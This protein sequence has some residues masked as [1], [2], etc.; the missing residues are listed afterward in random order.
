[1]LIFVYRV[2]IVRPSRTSEG[3]YVLTYKCQG[4]LA[5]QQIVPMVDKERNITVFT[6]DNGQTKF[7]DILQLI[8]FYTVNLGPLMCRLTHYI[9]ENA[10]IQNPNVPSPSNVPKYVNIAVNTDISINSTEEATLLE[11]PSG[12][13]KTTSSHSLS[14][15]WDKYFFK[16]RTHLWISFF[17][18]FITINNA[19]IDFIEWMSKM[20]YWQGV[21]IGFIFQWRNSGSIK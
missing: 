2:F 12:S 17:F 19:C 8:E 9:T 1:M 18:R 13:S 5:H 16:F 20:I 21:P 3:T 7:Y 11:S 14:S 15:R 4:K 10:N 6:L